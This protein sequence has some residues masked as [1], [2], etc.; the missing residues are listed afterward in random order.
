[1]L[2]RYLQGG[3][4]PG[5]LEHPPWGCATHHRADARQCRDR[6]AV[7]RRG[8]AHHHGLNAPPSCE[9][10]YQA[11]QLRLAFL[12]H[13]T[14]IHDHE[15]RGGRVVHRHE[16]LLRERL[17]HQRGVILVGLATESV[18]VDVHG[19]TVIPT[20]T[21]HTRSVSPPPR[22]SS[23]SR[24]RSMSARPCAN[25][26]PVPTDAAASVGGLVPGPN[27]NC[28][29]RAPRRIGIRREPNSAPADQ[30]HVS[31]A[32][33]PAFDQDRH[34]A[35]AANRALGLGANNKPP[36]AMRGRSVTAV[37]V[38]ATLARRRLSLRAHATM[39][40]PG[41]RPR[42]TLPDTPSPS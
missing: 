22:R 1:M 21:V 23:R 13:R 16:S 24:P 40:K 31:K 39:L 15:V 25:A 35:D 14:G 12:G 29:P 27:G 20:S 5:G 18:K 7:A 30:V 36:P 32:P 11:P 28:P 4:H 2:R 6:A 38:S 26:P 34:A 10:S 37:V 9:P 33:A 17:A 42:S 19:R 8:A 41:A 3:G